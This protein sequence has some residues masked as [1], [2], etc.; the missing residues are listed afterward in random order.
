MPVE[1]IFR[2]TCPCGKRYRVRNPYPGFVFT[3]PA[4]QRRHA[5]TAEM[6]RAEPTQPPPAA[7]QGEEEGDV[8]RLQDQLPPAGGDRQWARPL[9][10][11]QLRLAP[12]GAK[13]GAS[14]RVSYSHAD[15]QAFGAGHGRDL[16]E[17]EHE[18]QHQFREWMLPGRSQARLRSFAGDLA[19]TFH[20]AGEK[21]NYL[22]FGAI[23]GVW[24]LLVVVRVVMTAVGLWFL[25]P[26]LWPIWLALS[27]TFMHYAWLALTETAAGRDDIPLVPADWS[28]WSDAIKPLLVLLL[29]SFVCCVPMFMGMS[30]L[31]AGTPF[32]SAMLVALLAVGSIA[33]PAAVL[34]YGVTDSI[35]GLRP[36][37]VV[38]V[39]AVTRGVYVLA[40]L[41][42]AGVA[43][44]WWQVSGSAKALVLFVNPFVAIAIIEV[45]ATVITLYCTYV[46]F[47][48]LG[49]LQRHFG[50]RMPW[51][52]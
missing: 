3:C 11:L 18:A 17:R 25:T 24:T 10:T 13:P 51:A 52:G 35:T 12:R 22:V 21:S 30:F 38:R 16:V 20:F 14:G 50:P 32:R 34:A 7:S 29:I 2:D 37:Y 48:T 23:I 28:I 6:L 39:I 27:I 15:A 9:A 45:F 43:T 41:I 36:D 5:L 33:W 8:Y 4:C 19:A 42:V 26:L 49:L 46:V 1:T 40:W 31:P 47:R 44:L